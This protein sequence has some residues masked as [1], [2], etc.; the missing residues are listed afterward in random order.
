VGVGAIRPMECRARFMVLA[1]GLVMGLA[2]MVF[3]QASESELVFPTFI[4]IMIGTGINNFRTKK[5][6]AFAAFLIF[7]ILKALF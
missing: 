4:M 5:V 2:I 1:M 3:S 6:A 7:Q